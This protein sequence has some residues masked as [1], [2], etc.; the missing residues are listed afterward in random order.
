MNNF[1]CQIQ[2]T[3]CLISDMQ[4]NFTNELQSNIFGKPPQKSV[5]Y[6]TNLFFPNM[7]LFRQLFAAGGSVT[8]KPSQKSVYLSKNTFFII[9]FFQTSVF[10][11]NFF[12][13]RQRHS[14]AV[15][16]KVFYRKTCF[17]RKTFLVMKIVAVGAFGAFPLPI[18]VI[19]QADADF[20]VKSGV[21]SYFWAVF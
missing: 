3:T 18:A 5:F 13:R 2:S 15:P 20:E 12:R 4:I 1:T 17:H 21:A 16:K 6:Q 8:A 9:I 19:F 14:E 10:F 11:Q 7:S